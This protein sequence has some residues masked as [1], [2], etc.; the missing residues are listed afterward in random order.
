MSRNEQIETALTCVLNRM[1]DKGETVEQAVEAVYGDFCERQ[2]SEKQIREFRAKLIRM[3]NG[4]K[5]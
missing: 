1:D 5:K 2:W 4:A 3:F